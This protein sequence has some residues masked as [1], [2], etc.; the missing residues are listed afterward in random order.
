MREEEERKTS[1]ENRTN[2]QGSAGA[3][4]VLVVVLRC[5]V[6]L[7]LDW[8]V[9]RSYIC[10]PDARGS[11]CCPPPLSHA[12]SLCLKSFIHTHIYWIRI[13]SN[14]HNGQLLVHCTQLY[15]DKMPI[16]CGNFID[17]AQTGFYDGLHFHRVVRNT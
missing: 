8:L 10:N 4:S 6:L 16:T 17:L 14:S 5:C 12:H 1:E 7:R 9:C 15:T 2:E 3:V 13:R 11:H